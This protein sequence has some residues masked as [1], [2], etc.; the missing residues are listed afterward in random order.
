MTVMTLM[1]PPQTTTDTILKIDTNGRVR[2][3]PEERERLLDAFENSSM[4]AKAFSE[5]HGIKYPTFAYWRKMRKQAAAPSLPDEDCAVFAEINLQPQPEA[6]L[7]IFL[8]GGASL[9]MTTPAQAP[10]VRALLE[11]CTR[12][13]SC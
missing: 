2:T 7:D 5:H 13:G 6:G 10:L 9:R 3:P 11:A 4:T 12:N 8:P 1:N